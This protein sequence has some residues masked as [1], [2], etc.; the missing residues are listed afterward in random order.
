MVKGLIVLLVVLVVILLAN[1][2]EIFLTFELDNE[3]SS[4]L[5]SHL[6]NFIGN[7]FSSGDWIALGDVIYC[8]NYINEQKVNCDVIIG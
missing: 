5:K 2:A 1:H 7:S 4:K 6:V 8:N 3:L